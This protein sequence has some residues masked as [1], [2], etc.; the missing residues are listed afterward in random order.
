MLGVG[1]PNANVAFPDFFALSTDIW[2][3]SELQRFHDEVLAIH[4]N[5]KELFKLDFDGVWLDMN[6]P[7]SYGTNE[8]NPWYFN[9]PSHAKTVPLQC[10]SSKYDKPP[11]QTYS[12]YDYIH[13]NANVRPRFCLYISE[14]KLSE[15]L[16]NL[17]E[18]M[19]AISSSLASKTLCMAAISRAGPMY[20]VKNL[21]GL[22]Q[23]YVTQVALQNITHKRA[24]VLTRSSFPSGGKYAGHWLGENSATWYDMRTS[25]VSVQLFNM[26]GIPYVGADICGYHG[27]ATE[28]LCARWQQLGA[29]YTLSRNYNDEISSPHE[30]STPQYPTVWS[31]I[32]NVT[33]QANLFKYQHLPYLYTL[34]FEASRIGG[35]VIRPLF[36]EFSNDKTTHGISNQ[37]MWGS[38]MLIVPVSSAVR[39]ET[40]NFRLRVHDEQ[41]LFSNG[42]HLCGSKTDHQFQ[43]QSEIQAYLPSSAMWYSMRENIDYAQKVS[44]GSVLLSAPQDDLIPVFIRDE[45]QEAR[46][47]LVWDDGESI[48]NGYDTYCYDDLRMFFKHRAIQFSRVK[49]CTSLTVP[50]ITT[51]EVFGYTSPVPDVT[52]LRKQPGNI[53]LDNA[54]VIYDSQKQRL[55][56]TATNIYV[57][58]TDE[59]IIVGW[60]NGT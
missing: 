13:T 8:L 3:I 20:D 52:S 40:L 54:A 11:Y 5:K 46:G 58:S 4:N 26:F 35:T 59:N 24:N 34:M 36:F 39:I 27:N 44:G 55:L 15:A 43:D 7:T 42:K 49:K 25:I 51:I 9:D 37:F 23:S 53:P 38:A 1:R 12:V 60:D 56:I 22:R 6:E 28:D 14:N 41:R 17:T 50:S 10:P 57:F 29:F 47:Q 33:R 19:D 32:S 2:W 16:L 48:I 31:K 45:K 21:Y 18:H 30:T